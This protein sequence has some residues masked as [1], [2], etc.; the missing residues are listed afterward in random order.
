[1]TDLNGISSTLL[2]RFVGNGCCSQLLCFCDSSNK[3]YATAIYLRTI[4]ND[5]ITVN[6]VF[7]KARNAPKKKL[8]IPRLA[9][10]PVLIGTRSLHF[11]AKAMRL[12]IAEKTLWTDSQCLLQWIKNRENTSIFVRNRVTEI[13]NETDVVFRYINT[14][15]SPADIP[16]RGM[17]INELK[18]NKLWWYGPEWLLQDPNEWPQWNTWVA[19]ANS[20]SLKKGERNT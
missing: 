12:E 13:I 5:K 20:E 15:H 8:T 9:L 19:E 18:N 3:A 4:K 6:L 10:M 2:L 11:R 1:M 14:K 16:T 17:S 7:S